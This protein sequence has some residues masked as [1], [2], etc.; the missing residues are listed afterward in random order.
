MRSLLAQSLWKYASLSLAIG[1]SSLCQSAPRIDKP[2]LT[3]GTTRTHTDTT[4]E[5]VTFGEFRAEAPVPVPIF[6]TLPLV[7]ASSKAMTLQTDLEP[8]LIKNQIIGV[9]LLHHAQEGA[10]VW[11]Y[12]LGRWSNQ[13]DQPALWQ[14][15]DLNLDKL[16]PLLRP[17][18][19]DQANSW[20]ALNVTSSSLSHHVWPEFGWIWFTDDG[21]SIDIKAPE[22]ILLGWKEGY[23][24]AFAGYHQMLFTDYH[25]SETENWGTSRRSLYWVALDVKR[26]VTNQWHT[27]IGAGLTTD[28]Y[29]IVTWCLEWQGF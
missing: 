21:P 1:T 28:H 29:P 4:T 16:F 2:R 26:E 5:A 15:L 6:Q 19:S 11:K 23:W 8:R 25:S 13:T 24:H 18:N 20:F 7:H 17:K 14:R 27:N 22:H 9:G 3:L 10:P 12:Q